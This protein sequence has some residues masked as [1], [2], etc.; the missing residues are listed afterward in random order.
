MKQFVIVFKF[1]AF[2]CFGTESFCGVCIF[3]NRKLI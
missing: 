3:I 1:S 2:A